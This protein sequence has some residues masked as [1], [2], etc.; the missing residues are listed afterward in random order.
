MGLKEIGSN[1]G[2]DLKSYEFLWQQNVAKCGR[3]SWLSCGVSWL[4][5]SQMKEKYML[6][7]YSFRL[8]IFH[9]DSWVVWLNNRC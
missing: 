7:N 8:I 3:F 6:N 4:G 2:L 9:F 1:S 5:H